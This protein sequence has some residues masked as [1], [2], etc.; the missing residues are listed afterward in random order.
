MLT[1]P[2]YVPQEV[3]EWRHLQCL[4]EE[5]VHLEEALRFVEDG[6]GALKE[7]MDNINVTAQA[8]KGAAP[9]FK[10]AYGAEVVNV[11]EFLSTWVGF[12][13]RLFLTAA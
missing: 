10:C 12:C 11:T 5:L 3:T 1:L 6:A 8:L 13:Q 7:L 9:S 4:G 2:F